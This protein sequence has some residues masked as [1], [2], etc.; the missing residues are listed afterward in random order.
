MAKI[1]LTC[2]WPRVTEKRALTSFYSWA[3]L[4]IK[5]GFVLTQLLVSI[6]RASLD[7]RSFALS[8]VDYQGSGT[9]YF[10]NMSDSI[11]FAS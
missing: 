5:P 11:R 2:F 1:G 10:Q 9:V 3:R 4:A 8:V 7:L 6:P